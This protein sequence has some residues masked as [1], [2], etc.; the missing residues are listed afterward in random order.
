MR[1]GSFL[2]L[3][4]VEVGYTLPERFSKRLHMSNLRLYVNGT[5]LM[6][7]SSFD[8][9]DVEMGGS[10]LGYP[11]QRVFNFGLNMKF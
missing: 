3:K 7:L 6:N 4:Q 8:L 11:L 1:D 5:N 2:R 9:W 10:G